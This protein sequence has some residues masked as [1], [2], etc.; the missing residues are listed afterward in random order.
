MAAFIPVIFGV[1]AILAVI[2]LCAFY[3]IKS[4]INH[5][6]LKMELVKAFHDT[7]NVPNKNIIQNLNINAKIYSNLILT[8]LIIIVCITVST[9]IVIYLYTTLKID[10]LILISIIY[11][12]LY[13]V[14]VGVMS[15]FDIN[16][17]TKN[18]S[19]YGVALLILLYVWKVTN[20]N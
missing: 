18:C 12:I 17:N 1:V 8:Y 11:A 6:T 9:Y 20:Q 14:G 15:L 19:K 13:A 3:A 7:D 10:T 5:A 4:S 16:V 2:L